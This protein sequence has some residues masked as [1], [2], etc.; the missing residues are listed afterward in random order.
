M[1]IY[2]PTLL[3]L[4]AVCLLFNST[5]AATTTTTT[6]T[7]S[8][9]DESSIE[10]GNQH[11]VRILNENNERQ[12]QQ[13]P[14][15]T[16]SIDTLAMT[17]A[18]SEYY[19]NIVDQVM[20]TLTKEITL[21]APRSYMSIHHYGSVRRGRCRMSLR[22]F[23]HDLRDHLNLM[24][25]NLLASIRPLVESN[26]P[27]VLPYTQEQ[28]I[29]QQRRRRNMNYNNNNNNNNDNNNDDDKDI[30]VIGARLT[31]DILALNRHLGLQL[32]LILNVEEAADII[33]S[34]SMP[35]S[36]LLMEDATH[37]RES[38]SHR[39]TA[40]SFF[41]NNNN[42]KNTNQQQ[43]LILL[44]STEKKSVSI[45]NNE[46]E[47][48]DEMDEDEALAWLETLRRESEEQE[49]RPES[50]ALTHWLRSWLYEVEE[51]LRVQF[52][53]RVQDA[54]QLILE[55]FLVDDSY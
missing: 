3:S 46:V 29:Q 26:L 15:S 11:I 2:R 28:H 47:D 43:Q 45:Y 16:T 8:L 17:N 19:E 32:G 4:T 36:V 48:I 37:H 27:S 9:N 35:T 22:S 55:D 54:T 5:Y 49:Q 12:Q 34:Q 44:A 51:I 41:W 24:R 39:T 7:T 23:V 52:D 40:A 30:T 21:S 38:S 50:R 20:A 25:A 1:I 42:N 6:T 10:F 13:Q 31:E 33:I 53:E 18:L 14:P